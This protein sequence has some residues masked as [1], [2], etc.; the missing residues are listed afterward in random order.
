[1]STK[2]SYLEALQNEDAKHKN[3]RTSPSDNGRL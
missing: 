1:M 3:R 2:T